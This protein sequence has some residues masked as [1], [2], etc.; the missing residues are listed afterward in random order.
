MGTDDLIAEDDFDETDDQ[1]EYLY[2]ELESTVFSNKAIDIEK[3]AET[4]SLD[5][6]MKNL[7][8]RTS[9]ATTD[10]TKNLN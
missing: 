6:F 3:L 5:D 7:N 2:M 10:T 9:K 8:V 4:T 1:L